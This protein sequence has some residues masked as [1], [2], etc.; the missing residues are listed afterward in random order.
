M[1][2]T[3]QNPIEI[4]IKEIKEKKGKKKK[5]LS[6]QQKAKLREQLAKGRATALKNR[7][8]KALG[9]KIDKEE[10]EK[11]LDAKIAKKVLNKNPLQDEMAELKEELRF[12]KTNKGEPE[13]IAKLKEELT[14]IK[15]VM[16]KMALHQMSQSTNKEQAKKEP[17]PDMA[18][19]KEPPQADQ[20]SIDT[21]TESK[22]EVVKPKVKKVL[23]KK[24]NIYGF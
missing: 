16:K 9:K 8:K 3:E 23:G 20:V 6:E 15:E 12:L 1:S 22:K 13:E 18:T 19:P 17:E 7:Q 21:I 14:I 2:D 24:K 4:E 5:E 11:A 10:Q